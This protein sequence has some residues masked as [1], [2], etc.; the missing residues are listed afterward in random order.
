[1]RHLAIA[2]AAAATCLAAGPASADVYSDDLAKC[3][4]AK[5]TEND[6]VAFMRWFFAAMSASPAVSDMVKTDAVQRRE[7]ALRTGKLIERLLT[8]DCRKEAV[9]AVKYEGAR[10]FETSFELFGR[11]AVQGLM[12]DPAVDREMSAI[13]EGADQSKFEALAREAGVVPKK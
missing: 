4:V 10:T 6:R 1:M 12:A 3:L 8:V 13:G 11:V 9:L 7:Y 2:A 5:S